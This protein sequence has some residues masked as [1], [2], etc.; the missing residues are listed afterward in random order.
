MREEVGEAQALEA[1]AH[2]DLRCEF[3]FSSRQA[4][5]LAARGEYGKD[6]SDPVKVLCVDLLVGDAAGPLRAGAVDEEQQQV[7]LDAFDVGHCWIHDVG[8]LAVAPEEA[9]ALRV[10][11]QGV[12]ELAR[13][14]YRAVGEA[15]EVD[16]RVGGAL[17]VQAEYRQHALLAQQVLHAR[18]PLRVSPPQRHDERGHRAGPDVNGLAR[19]VVA[20]V[21]ALGP[22]VTLL[23]V[24]GRGR[25]E[26]RV[27]RPRG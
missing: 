19:D 12:G 6:K 13:A 17:I 24:H 7:R 23:A 11:G 9:E 8:R 4:R 22:H 10:A 14:Q 26:R 25:H 3:S 27:G 15:P 5:A 2:I 21:Y 1:A 18:R 16:K 20:R